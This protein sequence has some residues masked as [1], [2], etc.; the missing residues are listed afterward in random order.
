MLHDLLEQRRLIDATIGTLERLVTA[1]KLKGRPPKAVTE[2]R[3]ILGHASR[4]AH[5]EARQPP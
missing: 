3:D 4:A 2:A 1:A 5:A